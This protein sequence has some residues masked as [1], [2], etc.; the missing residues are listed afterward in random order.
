V[1]DAEDASKSFIYIRVQI[2]GMKIRLLLILAFCINEI[3]EEISY[4]DIFVLIALE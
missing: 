4:P 2:K 3:I 1:K